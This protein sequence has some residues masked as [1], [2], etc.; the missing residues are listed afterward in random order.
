MA[1]MHVAA[2][3]CDD[4]SLTLTISTAQLRHAMNTLVADVGADGQKLLKEEMRLL[5]SEI[6][7]KT[8][9]TKSPKGDEVKA[10]ARQRG[11]TAVENDMRRLASPLDWKNIEIP[12]LAKAV[13]GRNIPVINAILANL[14]GKWK[15]KTILPN[16]AAIQASHLQN[17]NRYGRIKGRYNQLSFLGDWSKYTRTIKARVGW[18]RAGWLAAAQALGLSLPTWVTRHRAYAPGGYYAPSA[19][20][21]TIIASNRSI[22]IPNYFERHVV[23][24]VKQRARSLQREVAAIVAGRGSRRGSLAGT[25]ASKVALK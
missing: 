14:G 15:N 18:T 4:M 22:K 5:L 1:R 13:H 25:S 20:N 16:V 6:L 11:N 12:A 8:P 2:G 24:A 7:R 21:L 19:G 23:P 17:R 3:V 10:N 9:P